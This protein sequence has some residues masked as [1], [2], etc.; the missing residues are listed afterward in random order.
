MDP[1]IATMFAYTQVAFRGGVHPDDSG[2]FCLVHHFGS[3]LDASNAHA[4]FSNDRQ[5]SGQLY[6][7]L[8]LF[9]RGD[10]L[11]VN[12]YVLALLLDMDECV[13]TDE[14]VHAHSQWAMASRHACMDT[15]NR[16]NITSTSGNSDTLPSDMTCTRG[17]SLHFAHVHLWG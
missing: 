14:C 6:T 5:A 12:G 11:F 13:H 1:W 10:V 8:H 17:S 15:K 16:C 7:L 3:H 2:D 9:V 4:A